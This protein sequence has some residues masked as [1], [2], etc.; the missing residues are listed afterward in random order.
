[1]RCAS[2]SRSRAA[3]TE[4]NGLIAG[5][6]AQFPVRPSQPQVSIG[7]GAER[8]LAA[9]DR[10]L[11]AGGEPAGRPARAGDEP[12]ADAALK[13]VPSAEKRRGGGELRSSGSRS[14]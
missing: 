1:M 14:P 5:W 7:A 13:P 4:A 6:E 3:F 10:R 11:P 2:R 12:G 8:W 9:L